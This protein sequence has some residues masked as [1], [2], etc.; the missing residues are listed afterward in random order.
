MTGVLLKYLSMVH[1]PILDIG[2]K[3]DALCPLAALVKSTVLWSEKFRHMIIEFFGP[4]A[5]GK[6]TLS[7]ALASQLRAQGRQVL[8]CTSARPSEINSTGNAYSTHRKTIISVHSAPLQRA[9]KLAGVLQSLFAARSQNSVGTNLLK[10]LP[11]QN[12]LSRLRLH[13][14]LYALNQS[15]DE[16]R[17]H[18][19]ITIF[20]QGYLTALSSVAVSTQI[21]NSQ[22]LA[23]A[24]ALL[25][26]PDLVICLDAPDYVL[27]SRV[28]LRHA[29]QTAIERLFEQDT[30]K[31]RKQVEM[32]RIVAAMLKPHN[33]PAVFFNSTD[34]NI[35][36]TIIEKIAQNPAPQ[37][38]AA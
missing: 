5:V 19:G 16:G 20:D 14:Y 3:C 2:C 1:Q 30:G 12:R 4:P 15:F 10:I 23:R 35:V 22:S 32:V 18:H 11:P 21:V 17:A 36:G 38:E 13:R 33:W 25:P 31:T 8:L 6:S 28:A 27:Q 7:N 26:R 37:W 24:F 34:D 29:R 9:A